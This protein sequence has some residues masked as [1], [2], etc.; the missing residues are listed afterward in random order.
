MFVLFILTFGILY[1]MCSAFYKM[2]VWWQSDVR[3]V[4]VCD[5][6]WC[7]PFSLLVPQCFAFFVVQFEDSLLVNV[8]CGP[9]VCCP[10]PGVAYNYV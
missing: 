6:L 8:V 10:V 9:P 1:I 4:W 3:A 2:M 7:L 5:L